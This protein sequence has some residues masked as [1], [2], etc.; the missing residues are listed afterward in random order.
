MT[1]AEIVYKFE[2]QNPKLET[3]LNDQKKHQNVPNNLDS[4]SLFW[5]FLG[6]LIYLAAV[7]FGF[8]YSYFGFCLAGP[9]P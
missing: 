7:C 5:N 2:T 3:N 4:D 1:R 8:R 9:L 6:F